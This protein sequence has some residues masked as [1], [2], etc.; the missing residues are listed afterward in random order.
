MA[1]VGEFENDVNDYMA[2]MMNKWTSCC[3]EKSLVVN[4]CHDREIFNFAVFY[5]NHT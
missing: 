3:S 2:Q 4:C 5:V 1:V